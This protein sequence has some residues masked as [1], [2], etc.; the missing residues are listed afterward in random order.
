[1]Y[2]HLIPVPIFITL[3]ILTTLNRAKNNY[4]RLKKLQPATT[5][6]MIS[7]SAL[8]IL[9]P[10]TNIVYYALILAALIAALIGET[11]MIELHNSNLMKAIPFYAICLVLYGVTFTVF[12]KG[13]HLY[14]LIPSAIMLTVY[15]MIMAL[16]WKGLVK[17][18]MIIP[19]GIYALIWCIVISRAFCTLFDS[20]LS[21]PQSIMISIGAFL[22]F[23]GDLQLALKTYRF[24]GIDLFWGASLYWIGQFMI[25]ISPAYF[26]V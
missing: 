14:D 21:R 8:T 23:M 16:M 13:F 9:S 5:L 7:C 18:K 26:A 20:N 2:Y 24:P 11:L 17:A 19:V 10:G 22:F 15:G 6:V 4:E 1:M 12:N 25:A 3:L